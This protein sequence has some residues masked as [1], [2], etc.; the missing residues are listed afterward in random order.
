MKK[1]FKR[2]VYGAYAL[3]SGIF[4]YVPV[5]HHALGVFF[6]FLYSY[7]SFFASSIYLSQGTCSQK[8]LYSCD[9]IRFVLELF[10]YARLIIFGIWHWLYV[11]TQNN[12][13]LQLFIFIFIY[14]HTSRCIYWWKK[15]IIFLFFFTLVNLINKIT[16]I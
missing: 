9:L 13:N 5:Q 3:S 10:C 8:P 15:K 12:I 7:F 14:Y 1:G 16:K 4:V 2:I 11:Y 6:L